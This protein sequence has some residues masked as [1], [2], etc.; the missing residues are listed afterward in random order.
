[1]DNRTPKKRPPA[2]TPE[3]RENQ[4]I[5]MAYDLAE[6]QIADG[7]ASSQVVHHFLKRGSEKERLE[8]EIKL[9]EKKL[10]TAKTRAIESSERVETL[11]KQALDAMKLYSGS[12][13]GAND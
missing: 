12:E 1:M 8:L 9:E 5:A 2:T 7:T 11:Y 4:L 13:G 3:A 10:I 6:K